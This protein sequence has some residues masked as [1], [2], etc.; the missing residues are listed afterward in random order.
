MEERGS[1]DEWQNVLRWLSSSSS[2]TKTESTGEKVSGVLLADCDYRL[3]A[4]NVSNEA[5]MLYTAL[6][7]AR[8]HLY[9]IEVENFGKGKKQKGVRLSDFAFRRFEDLGL[10]ESVTF[11]DEGHVEMTAA[12]H[13]ARGVLYVTQALTMSRN[14]DPIGSVKD[15]LTEAKKRFG[16]DQGND[17]DLLDKCEKHLSAVLQKHTLMQFAKEKFLVGGEYNLEGR[18]AEVLQFEL[19]ASK[20]FSEFLCD[21]F[22]FEEVHV[23]KVV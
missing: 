16:P 15:K 3:S 12:Q 11:I 2:I 21:S 13:K 8:N 5:M 23:S 4:P 22:L 14:R 17:D 7:R 1:S 18:F 20:F 10:T 19:N 9:L 6:T